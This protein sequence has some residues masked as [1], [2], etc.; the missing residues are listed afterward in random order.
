MFY[1]RFKNDDM[2]IT[3]VDGYDDKMQKKMKTCIYTDGK[4]ER[5]LKKDR[6][7]DHRPDECMIIGSLTVDETMNNVVYYIRKKVKIVRPNYI[8]I[9]NYIYSVSD[10]SWLLNNPRVSLNYKFDMV[11][12]LK[13][14]L[15][16]DNYLVSSLVEEPDS[17]TVNDLNDRIKSKML[18]KTIKKKG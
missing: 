4:V 9:A 15:F 5:S 7:V 12:E 11:D 10:N 3:L 8:V 6:L 13:F 1:G 2:I 17:I 18:M 14:I 16:Q